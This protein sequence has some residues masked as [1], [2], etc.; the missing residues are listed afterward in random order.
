MQ[1]SLIIE[2]H[3][4]WNWPRLQGIW[5]RGHQKLTQRPVFTQPKV[6]AFCSDETHFPFLTK[7]SQSWAV[8]LTC[9]PLSARAI[10][11][12]QCQLV[13]IP[14]IPMNR[15]KKANSLGQRSEKLV[16]RER[17]ERESCS[18][19]RPN[20]HLLLRVTTTILFIL[21]STP[22]I[23]SKLDGHPSPGFLGVTLL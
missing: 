13:S 23:D 11:H 9:H 5:P 2:P 16:W 4:R 20:L 15:T 10:L 18:Q 6:R 14:I 17:S 12:F 21:K 1:C 22:V 19:A 7:A 3:F 8:A